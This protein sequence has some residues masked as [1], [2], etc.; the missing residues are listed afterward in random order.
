MDYFY[1]MSEKWKAYDNTRPHFVTF[2]VSY[3]IDV[4]SRSE[5]KDIFCDSV[6]HCQEKKGLELYAWVL[7]SNHVHMI[8]GSKGENR[9]S[10]IIRDLKK[11]TSVRIVR[12]IEHN[13]AESRREW[14]LKLF[15]HGAAKSAKHDKFMFW[16]QEYHPVELNSH[17]I[18]EQKLLYIHDN[19][20]RA[21]IVVEPQHYLY[22]S[23]ID[24]AGGKGLLRIENL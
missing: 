23:A 24:Y 22:S 21:G 13:I 7:M 2:A 5:Y 17:E 9:I 10:D 3:W 12:A 15:A 11:Y 16:Q 18:Y 14:M 8:I 1:R 20:V 19:P 4:F 6:K